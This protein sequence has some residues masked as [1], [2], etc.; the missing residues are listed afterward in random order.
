MLLYIAT[1]TCC[2]SI[3][4]NELKNIILLVLYPNIL[5]KSN[6]KWSDFRDTRICWV[7]DINDGHTENLLLAMDK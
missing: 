2:V 3:S 4:Q 5:S 7:I 6:W 1:Y